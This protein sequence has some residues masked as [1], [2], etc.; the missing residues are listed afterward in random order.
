MAI[1]TRAYDWEKNNFGLTEFDD[2]AGWAF[3]ELGNQYFNSFIGDNFS[4]VTI[5]A[6]PSLSAVTV[7]SATYTDQSISAPN[8]TE[9]EIISEN[10]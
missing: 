3:T 2:L 1:N 7:G 8:Y 10:F 4:S 9:I 5:L 6:S